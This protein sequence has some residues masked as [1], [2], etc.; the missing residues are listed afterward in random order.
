MA[1]RFKLTI[2]TVLGSISGEEDA[3]N[4]KQLRA[5]MPSEVTSFSI[6]G[7]RDRPGVAE[8]SDEELWLNLLS[9]VHNI[10]YART[11]TPQVV[12]RLDAEQRRAL[13]GR[14]VEVVLMK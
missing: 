8:V 4:E 5:C 11:L 3:N 10:E 12:A 13:S 2:H 9:A 6:N 14:R 1:S 7:V